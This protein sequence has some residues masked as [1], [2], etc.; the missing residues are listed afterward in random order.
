[1]S[2][3]YCLVAELPDAMFDGS[4]PAFTVERFKEEVYPLLSAADARIIDMFF[5]VKD[6]ENIL[7][8]LRK[9]E[10]AVITQVGRYSH[11]ELS[12]IIAS[13]KNG[14]T[15]IKGVPR[16]IYD[17]I[18]FYTQNENSENILWVDV[19][20]AH[21]Y[22]YATSCANK[23]VAGWFTF[24]RDVNNILAAMAARKYK[25]NVADVVVGDGEVAECLRTSGARD[26][27]LSGTFEYIELLQRMCE[28]NKLQER[29]HQLDEL[30]WRWL[31]ENSVFNYFTIERLFVF[32]VKLGIV[33]RWAK[34]DAEKGME[35]YKAI[36]ADLKSGMETHS[37]I[38]K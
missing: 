37:M 1:M 7:E 14:D 12:E 9:G 21:Y 22:N 28:N 4:V 3:Y 18:E 5:L 25:M 11:A 2:N 6:N 27:G 13:A 8:I 15:P 16:Y 29:E 20:N 19:M 26:F 31:D 36:I 33:E 23:F 35:C 38:V 24:N 30:R 17:F 34:L 10:N 32:L